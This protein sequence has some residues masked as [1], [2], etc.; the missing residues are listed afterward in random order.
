MCAK[1]FSYFHGMLSVQPLTT[2]IARI[3]VLGGEY[4]GDM[5]EMKKGYLVLRVKR[6]FQF[7]LEHNR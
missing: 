2:E 7:N 1:P 3:F 4:L 6:K 5:E